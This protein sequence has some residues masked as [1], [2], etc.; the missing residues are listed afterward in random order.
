MQCTET[1]LEGKP[2]G[3]YVLSDGKCYSHGGRRDKPKAKSR[4]RL[5]AELAR[6]LAAGEETAVDS[7]LRAAAEDWRAA[8]WFLERAHPERWGKVS[9]ALRSPTKPPEEAEVPPAVEPP[10]SG[11]PFREVD[12]LADRRRTRAPATV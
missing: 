6:K 10:P 9:T 8:A 3:G 1:N 2:C 5:S 11:D 12:E 7:I 4:L